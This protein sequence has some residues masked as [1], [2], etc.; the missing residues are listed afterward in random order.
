MGP[1]LEAPVTAQS[2]G[3]T[4]LIALGPQLRAAH[5][6]LRELADLP[7]DWDGYGSPPI[8]REA[9][10]TAAALAERLGLEK[11]PRTSIGPVPGGGIQFEWQVG[12]RGLELEVLPDGGIAYLIVYGPGQMDE[13]H[14]RLDQIDERLV[15][16]IHDWV[17]TGKA[18]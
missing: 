15:D 14:L 1:V 18:R 8:N 17:V 11:W 13:G 7:M 5:S 10:E 9:L 2:E 4:P 12:E 6:A 16:T 3:I